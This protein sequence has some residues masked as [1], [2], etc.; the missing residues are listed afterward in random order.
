MP[1]PTEPLLY[2]T[3]IFASTILKIGFQ[4]SLRP[5]I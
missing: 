4:Y 1:M 2:N 5:W 3:H